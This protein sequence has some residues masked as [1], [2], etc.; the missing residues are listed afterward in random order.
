MYFLNVITVVIGWYYYLYICVLPA[1]KTGALDQLLRRFRGI[2][3]ASSSLVF[4]DDSRPCHL[5]GMSR[6]S[7]PVVRILASSMGRSC[8]ILLGFPAITFFS[9]EFPFCSAKFSQITCL[10]AIVMLFQSRVAVSAGVFF[11]FA[12]FWL[13]SFLSAFSSF[14]G[15]H[16]AGWE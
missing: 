8:A 3:S 2:W 12:V 11:D 4:P 13:S 10:R 1:T 5:A 9:P 16:F 15:V 14:A 7:G 6:R